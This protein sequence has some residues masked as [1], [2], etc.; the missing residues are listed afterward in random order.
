MEI[1]LL[2]H[3][4]PELELK[5]FISAKEFKNLVKQYNDAGIRDEPPEKL[6]KYFKSYYVICSNLERSIQSAIKLDINRINLTDNLFKEA[7]IPHYDRGFIKLPVG[8]WLIFFRIMCLFGFSQNGESFI[9][10]KKR[11]VNAVKM[12][13]A[14]AEENEKLIIIGHGLM[15]RLIA[16]QLITEGWKGPVSPGKKYWQF[17]QYNKSI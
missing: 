12:L 11:A 9:Q 3:G 2:R 1:I 7:D 10:A 14:L 4:E 16:K 5:G 13:T 8:I 15:N 17:G 6:K